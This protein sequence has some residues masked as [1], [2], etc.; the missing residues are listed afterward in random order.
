MQEKSPNKSRARR[1]RPK[2][3]PLTPREQARL[4]KERQRAKIAKNELA[5]LEV[6]V[7]A[8][9]REAIKKSSD[10]RTLS[11]VGVE[12]FQLWLD[13]KSKT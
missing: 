8:S 13:L 12:A 5:K 7:P 1:G 9:L 3:S 4:R 11:E 10:G 6:L 2:V